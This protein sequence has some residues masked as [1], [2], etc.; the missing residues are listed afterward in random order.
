[1]YVYAT[2]LSGYAHV[3]A[4]SGC[5]HAK[6]MNGFIHVKELHLV[7]VRVSFYTSLFR[8]DE[9]IVRLLVWV[10]YV[11]A[12]EDAKPQNCSVIV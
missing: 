11:P 7:K 5:V 10:S 4:I 12:Y 3:M 9:K 6:A 1:M 2:A 8:E